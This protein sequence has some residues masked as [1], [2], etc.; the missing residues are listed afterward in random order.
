M[1]DFIDLI[2][3]LGTIILTIV[4]LIVCGNLT[5]V[6]L[7][8]VGLKAI[9]LVG[10]IIIALVTGGITSIIGLVIWVYNLF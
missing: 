5:N 9:P 8:A 6:A 10:A 3:C 7:V 1:S 2:G 4:I